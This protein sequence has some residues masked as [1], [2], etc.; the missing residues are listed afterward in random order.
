MGL[1]ES[2]KNAIRD[3]I[4]KSKKEYGKNWKK[5][6]S[7]VLGSVMQTAVW[8]GSAEHAIDF[9]TTSG[10]EEFDKMYG[11][12]AEYEYE[13]DAK[14]GKIKYRTRSGEWQKAVIG[15]WK[16]LSMARKKLDKVV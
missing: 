10:K 7:S 1:G 2:L 5:Y 4:S 15:K 8:K 12:W 9:S 11:D 3:E 16:S 13:V 6:S 14:T